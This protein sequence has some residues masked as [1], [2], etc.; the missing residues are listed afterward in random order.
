MLN[1]RPMETEWLRQQVARGS[2]IY[3]HHDQ[4]LRSINV[5][6][7]WK[8]VNALKKN[9]LI[10]ANNIIHGLC[11]RG[12]NWAMGF[13]SL[14]V[15]HLREAYPTSYI[16]SCAIAPFAS[17]E[18]PLQHYN[19]MLSLSWLHRF[20]DGI[21]MLPNDAFHQ[22]S[23]QENGKRTNGTKL[24][25]WDIN[26][27]MS[28][29]LAGVL[30]LT[31]SLLFER[32]YSLGSEPWYLLKTLCSRPDTKI[33]SLTHKRLRH[34]W[35]QS[36]T[37]NFHIFPLMFFSY[38]SVS[39]ILVGRGENQSYDF[40]RAIQKRQQQIENNLNCVSWNPCPVDYWSAD[41]CLPGEK[42]SSLT[43]A[44]NT[45]Y[46]TDFLEKTLYKA[47]RMHENKAYLH[48][49]WKHGASQN[50]F[51]NAFETVQ[52]IIDNYEAVATSS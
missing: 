16:L 52:R 6:S 27:S 44:S 28:Q 35:E 29:A 34:S 24:P 18:S 17:G 22:T 23:L 37:S 42:V 2:C 21:V 4:K 19:S 41:H 3:Q 47:K 8:T 9:Q 40:I 31:D 15:E 46:V 13:G 11:G 36:L 5:D 20:A 1:K 30:Y 48:W 51:E 45:G 12:N 50:D 14:V 38:K 43:L 39:N 25:V 26:H 7:E 10:R 49:Y 33:I 32:G